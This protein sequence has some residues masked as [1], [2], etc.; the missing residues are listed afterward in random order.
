MSPRKNK[1]T[2]LALFLPVVLFSLSCTDTTKQGIDK[3]AS[4]DS[5]PWSEL[6]LAKD[7]AALLLA[8]RS[9]M[10]ADTNVAM[11]TLDAEGRPRV[12]TVYPVIEEASAHTISNQTRIW[13]MTRTSTRKM[14]QLQ[15]D[16][17]VTLYYNDD[18]T[19]RYASIMGVA[20][21][22]TD[23]NAAEAAQFLN[24]KID[25]A[26][27]RFFWPAFPKDFALISIRPQWIEYLGKEG[28]QADPETWR[29]Q[30]VVFAQ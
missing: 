24:S 25:S 11:I 26:M 8:A 21:I 28:V 18:A 17:R 1:V 19:E 2:G 30:A 29:P 5:I 16:P 15:S 13:V 20:T 10:A 22:F 23:H 4:L 27:I 14:S 7:S 3:A 12:R 9:L 6:N